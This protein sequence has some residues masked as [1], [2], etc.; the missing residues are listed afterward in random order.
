MANVNRYAGKKDERNTILITVASGVTVE[1]GDFMFLDSVDDL[2]N[3]GDSTATNQ[4][5]PFENLRISGSSL[6]LNKTAARTYFLGIALDDKDGIDGGI[7]QNI[8]V[9]TKGKFN[10][11]LK[12]PKSVRVYHQFGASGTTEASNLFNQKVMVTDNED[13]ILGQFAE[14]KTYAQDADAFI[15]TFFTRMN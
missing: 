12:P 8:T 13:W 14:A 10:L 15:Q 1:M 6:D 11:D 4:G 2:R 9:A 3:N 7:D 5:W